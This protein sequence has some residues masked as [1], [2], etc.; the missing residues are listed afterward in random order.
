MWR[1][2]SP[3]LITAATERALSRPAGNWFVLGA[4]RAVTAG[5]PFG[6]TVA[7]QEVVAWRGSGGE[8]L[9]GPGACPHLGAPLCDGRVRSGRLICH[10]HGM[11]IDGRPIAGWAPYPTYDDGVLAWVRLD[12]VGGETPL[13]RPVLPPRPSP[14]RAIEAVTETTGV[15]EPQD[16]LANRLDPWHGGWLHPYSFAALSVVEAPASDGSGPDR[17]VVDVSY[18]LPGRAMVVP[19]RAVFTA[20]D[21]RTVV[22]RVQDG[23]GA[24]SVVETHAVPV[25]VDDRGRPLTSVVEAVIAVSDRPGFAVGRL[26]A[27]ALRPLV[28]RTAARLWRDDLAYAQRRWQLRQRGRLPG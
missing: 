20:P 10:W 27:P 25:G 9:A 23:E 16:V 3:A 12:V 22:M 24:G 26:L 11:P 19:T 2:A 17:F 1:A 5:R 8:L 18:R 4:T 28:R 13:D 15:C 6:R 21:R 7:G 14:A